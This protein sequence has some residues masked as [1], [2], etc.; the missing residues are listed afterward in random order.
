MWD[1][2]YFMVYLRHKEETEFSGVESYVAECQIMEN[3]EWLPTKMAM[4]LET[5]DSNVQTVQEVVEQTGAEIKKDFEKEIKQL[6]AMV[7]ELGQE[8]MSER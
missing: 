3:L 6:K 2:L 1:Y 7:Q 8:V 4:C 5:E